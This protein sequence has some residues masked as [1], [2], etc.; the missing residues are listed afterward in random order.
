MSL[1]FPGQLGIAGVDLTQQYANK[2]LFWINPKGCVKIATSVEASLRFWMEMF[3]GVDNDADAKARCRARFRVGLVYASR[4]H[5]NSL[6]AK[7]SFAVKFTSIDQHL[8]KKGVID[9]RGY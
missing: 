3:F 5:I 6:A 7:D 4:D 2:L 1:K 8:Q 9:C